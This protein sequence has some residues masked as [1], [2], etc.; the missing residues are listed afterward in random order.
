MTTRNFTKI[1]LISTIISTASVFAEEAS[2]ASAMD[3]ANDAKKTIVTP[4][5]EASTTAKA[6]ED[7][8][9]IVTPVAADAVAAELEASRRV[10]MEMKAPRDQQMAAV[11]EITKQIEAR[12][13]AILETNEEAAKLTADIAE[14]DKTLE[15]KVLALTAV[16]DADQELAKLQIKMQ[17]ARDN[18]GKSQLKLRE[19]IAR[20]HRERR[21]AIEKAAQQKEAAA[22]ALADESAKTSAEQ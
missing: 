10:I 1:I 17:E 22:K 9:V 11:G 19:E 15:E 20:Q 8:E 18:F 7:E 16:F 4:V 14:L 6:K 3:K 5:A 12:R 13:K 21:L 2:K